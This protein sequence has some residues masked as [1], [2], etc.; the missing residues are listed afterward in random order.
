[1]IWSVFCYLYRLIQV[2]FLSGN[3]TS[4]NEAVCEETEQYRGPAFNWIPLVIGLCAFGGL[5]VMLV[6][7][8]CFCLWCAGKTSQSQTRPSGVSNTG[9]EGAA[10]AYHRRLPPLENKPKTPQ[11]GAIRGAEGGGEGFTYGQGKG[12]LGCE[13]NWGQGQG[14]HAHAGGVEPSN[15]APP[16]PYSQEG[17]VDHDQEGTQGHKGQS[18]SQGYPTG[19]QGSQQEHPRVGLATWSGDAH[20]PYVLPPVPTQLEPG[21]SSKELYANN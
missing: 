1:M 19:Q 8:G 15:E 11:I 16:P 9:V 10:G 18:G 17:L 12:G 5:L 3:K 20:A 7:I 4:N 13:S 21:P 2:S 6:L 14:E